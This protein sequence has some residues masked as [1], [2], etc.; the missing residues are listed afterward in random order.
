MVFSEHRFSVSLL[1]SDFFVFFRSAIN[2]QREWVTATVSIASHGYDMI[3][4]Y[5]EHGML[6]MD[7][8]S[9]E[10]AGFVYRLCGLGVIVVGWCPVDGHRG[11]TVDWPACG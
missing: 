7:M 3:P 10:E 4:S 5:R 1:F 11:R 8:I 6:H 2:P 9:W